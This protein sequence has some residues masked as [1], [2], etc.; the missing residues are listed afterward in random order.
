M[1]LIHILPMDEAVMI[2]GGLLKIHQ[3]LIS[4]KDLIL[5]LVIGDQILN[6]CVNHLGVDLGRGLNHVLCLNRV[7]ILNKEVIVGVNQDLSLIKC[8]MKWRV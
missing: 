5:V 6:M 8:M 3:T 2:I 7:A 4:L 1:L